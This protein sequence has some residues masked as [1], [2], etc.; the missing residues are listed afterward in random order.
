MKIAPTINFGVV[1]PEQDSLT[2][3]V[4]MIRTI[5]QNLS[6]A[7]NGQIGFGD[8]TNVDNINGSWINVIAPAAPNTD[9]T[10][11]HNL[12]RIPSGYWIMQKDRACDIYTGGVAATSTQ[13]T[14]RATVASAVLRLFIIGLLLFFL[15]SISEGQGARYDNVALKTVTVSGSSGISGGFY[16]FSCFIVETVSAATSSTLPN[17]QVNFTDADSSTALSIIVA[18]TNTTNT[19]GSVGQ[20]TTT[21]F[22]AA[23]TFYAKSGVAIQ[24]ATVGYASNPVSTMTYAVHIRLEGPF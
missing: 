13:L 9:F 19:V 4:N 18:T 5:Y 2:K 21:G 23:P 6:Q 8:G 22:N 16:R 7:F 17:C 15:P 12:G 24:Y 20:Q 14:L 11:N 1:E 10:V 3:F